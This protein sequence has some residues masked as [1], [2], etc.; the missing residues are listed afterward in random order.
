[1]QI[2]YSWVPLYWHLPDAAYEGQK[3]EL[4]VLFPGFLTCI[5][6]VPT[7]RSFVDFFFRT[8]SLEKSIRASLTDVEFSIFGNAFYGGWKQ[9]TQM[10]RKNYAKDIVIGAYTVFDLSKTHAQ[11]EAEKPTYVRLL[12]DGVNLFYTDDIGAMALLLKTTPGKHTECR[13][14][15]RRSYN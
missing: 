12:K 13:R 9:T 7:N 15:K 14:L 10:L 8:G 4:K 2:G 11:I 3:F 6:N 1:M 5:D